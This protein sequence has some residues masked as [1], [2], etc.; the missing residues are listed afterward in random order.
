MK[1]S[2]AFIYAALAIVVSVPASAAT[3]QYD[4]DT[5][6]G[7]TAASGPA[8]WLTATFDDDNSV[9]SVTL[10]LSAQA[11]LTVSDID[12]I[13]FSYDETIGD[14]AISQL[15]I[16]AV[17]SSVET[18]GP[19]D[20]HQADGDGKYDI[21]IELPNK[22]GKKTNRFSAG[23]TISYTFTGTGLTADSFFFLSTPGGA[24]GPFYA[25]AHVL[26]TGAC[27]IVNGECEYEDSDWIAP[28]TAV[29][30]PAA[31]WMLGSGLGMLGWMRRRKTAV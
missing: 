19:F 4:F 6:F 21:F 8:P 3:L 13:Y 23:D 30:V 10:T 31:V 18:V 20:G 12:Q 7:D 1:F 26:S 11:S 9:G 22:N 27:V 5:S 14:L 16:S 15:D 29:P 28:T 25:A 17:S 24:N 2:A